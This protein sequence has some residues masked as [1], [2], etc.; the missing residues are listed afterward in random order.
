MGS[1]SSGVGVPTLDA[2]ARRAGVSPMT[3]SRVV[4]QPTIV[5]QTTRL[6]VEA[7]V[8]ELGYVPNMVA[9]SLASARTRSASRDL[10]VVPSID[11]TRGRRVPDVSWRPGS[12][13]R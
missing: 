1:A 7:A 12:R 13:S 9:G 2:V 4:R 8:R 10:P 5:A 6:R 11:A 3:V